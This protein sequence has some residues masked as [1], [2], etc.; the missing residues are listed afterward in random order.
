MFNDLPSGA[1]SFRGAAP[2]ARSR[3][4]PSS[5]GSPERRAVQSGLVNSGLAHAR[6]LPSSRLES[7][8]IDA[9]EKRY[10]GRL[11]HMRRMDRSL[12]GI[13]HRELFGGSDSRL[14]SARLASARALL[15]WYARAYLPHDPNPNE[16]TTAEEATAAAAMAATARE[17]AKAMAAAAAAGSRSSES[18]TASLD[19][20][21]KEELSK[22]KA[23]E[24]EVAATLA[25]HTASIVTERQRLLDEF[26]QTK[27][28]ESAALMEELERVRFSMGLV[29][30]RAQARSPEP[31]NHEPTRESPVKA[32]IMAAR[33]HDESSQYDGYYS[34]TCMGT[35][36]AEQMV[37]SPMHVRQMVFYD[38]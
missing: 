15:P 37:P 24:N 16:N 7:P 26:G 10:L 33:S 1:Y 2:S 14:A 4:A 30:V 31:R 27:A 38:A 22:L 12:D 20:E 34:G 17:K 29:A 19:D 23:K 9:R 6:P 36:I 11:D 35:P 21:A 25:R 8:P 32:M 5:Q 18:S 3:L 13:T 28:E